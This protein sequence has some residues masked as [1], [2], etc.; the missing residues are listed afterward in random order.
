MDKW[1]DIDRDLDG[2]TNVIG[3][4][5]HPK[6]NTH[7]HAHTHIGKGCRTGNTR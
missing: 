4:Y 7:T 5:M 2:Y 3:L 6:T 1:V